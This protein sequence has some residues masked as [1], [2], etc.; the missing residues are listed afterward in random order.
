MI[1]SERDLTMISF[2][3]NNTTTGRP[4]SVNSLDITTQHTVTISDGV[5][6]WIGEHLYDNTLSVAENIVQAVANGTF[7]TAYPITLKG[8]VFD[9]R[10]EIIFPENVI[11]ENC[12]VTSGRVAFHHGTANAVSEGAR[13]AACGSD[14]TANAIAKGALAYAETW[15]ATANATAQMAWAIAGASGATANATAGGAHAYAAV[16]GA[17][18]NATAKGADAFANISGSTANATAN[19]AQASARASGATAN[20]TVA[21]AKASAWEPDSVAIARHALARVDSKDVFGGKAISYSEFMII[22]E[23]LDRFFNENNSKRADAAYEVG[24]A[25]CD[26]KGVRQSDTL[27]TF[28]L[29]AAHDL[30]F[31]YAAFELGELYSKKR[32]WFRRDQT[33]ADQWYSKETVNAK[34]VRELSPKYALLLQSLRDNKSALYY[35][36][37][38]VIKVIGNLLGRH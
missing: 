18:A 3:T 36:P 34:K 23:N 32:V 8:M 1:N 33:R 11:L 7:P 16:T 10:N 31:H 17:T 29:S 20:A 6:D 37:E 27:A 19:G 22:S 13:V 12:Q 4:Y 5:K 21:G 38:D 35:F 26:G 28:F 15:G 24:M 25:F 30:G 2:P 14:A 9:Q